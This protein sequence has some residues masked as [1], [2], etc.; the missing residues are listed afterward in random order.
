MH[1]ATLKPYSPQMVR[2]MRNEIIKE[3]GIDHIRYVDLR[4]TCAILALKNGTDAKELAQM[5][6]HYNKRP[7]KSSLN[8]K[9]GLLKCPQFPSISLLQDGYLLKIPWQSRLRPRCLKNCSPATKFMWRAL[10]G[11]STRRIHLRKRQQNWS[12]GLKFVENILKIQAEKPAGQAMKACPAVCIVIVNSFGEGKCKQ[13]VW[14]GGVRCFLLTD[15]RRTDIIKAVM[16]MTIQQILR[17]KNISRY[18]LSKKSGVPWATLADICSG[19]TTLSRCSAGTLM[20]LSSTLD[21]PMEQLIT[22]T[23]EKP[24]MHGGKPID[25]SYLEKN[26]PASLDKA[27]REYVQGEK[28]KVS[29]MDCLWGELYSAINS[30]QWSNAITQEQADYLRAKYL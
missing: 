24:Q 8:R 17:E 25:R 20:K 7:K 23:V 10:A 21:I 19:K 1:P 5:L 13:T 26:L 12:Y 28:D 2:R 30:N 4:H 29:Y 3:A 15:Y 9:Q 14:S 27:L 18:Q 22:L 16:Y 11:W 6:G